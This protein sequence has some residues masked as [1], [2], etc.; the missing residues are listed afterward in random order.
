MAGAKLLRSGAISVV[1]YC[2]D[3]ATG[4]R[5]FTE[6]HDRSTLAYVRKGSFGYRARGKSYE[7][8]AGSVLVGHRGDEYMCTHDHASG[9]ECLS[10]VSQGLTTIRRQRQGDAT[11]EWQVQLQ[12]RCPQGSPVAVEL[13]VMDRNNTAIGYQRQVVQAPPNAAFAATGQI[14]IQAQQSQLVA[15]TIARWGIDTGAQ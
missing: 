4:D 2:C 10:L 15:S 11:A 13:W 9:D 6:V 1:D 7:L 3:A 5:P 12:N 14:A 8:V